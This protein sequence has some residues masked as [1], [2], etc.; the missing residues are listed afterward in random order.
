MDR[1]RIVGGR[2]LEGAVTISGAKN[3]AM[4]ARRSNTRTIPRT[5]LQRITGVNTTG[6]PRRSERCLEPGQGNNVGAEAVP[7]EGDDRIGEHEQDVP[8]EVHASSHRN[9]VEVGP[10]RP[11][12][13]E[14]GRE[15]PAGAGINAGE[16]ERAGACDPAEGVAADPGGGCAGRGTAEAAGGGCTAATAFCGPVVP[17]G[18]M[19]RI[20]NFGCGWPG[21]GVMASILPWT[22]RS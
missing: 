14:R 12:A 8:P 1:L 19:V 20:P 18:G 11:E 3:A 9:V 15:V 6:G 7:V 10:A 5:G 21:G 13:E 22:P 17:L 2:R 4:I 16:V